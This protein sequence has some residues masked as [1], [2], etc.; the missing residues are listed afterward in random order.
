MTDQS[1]GSELFGGR[2]NNR[3]GGRRGQRARPVLQTGHQTGNMVA[4]RFLFLFFFLWPLK[5]LQQQILRP[6][7]QLS[8][9]GCNLMCLKVMMFRIILI[10]WRSC[11]PQRCLRRKVILFC[12]LYLPI[13]AK[14][15][16]FWGTCAGFTTSL[17]WMGHH[18]WLGLEQKKPGKVFKLN[19][20]QL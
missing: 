7:S 1:Q 20:K 4:G 12:L 9:I 5:V 3:V 18:L 8:L 10:G 2:A 15:K 6:V 16:N 17:K 11:E 19:N 14:V 13:D